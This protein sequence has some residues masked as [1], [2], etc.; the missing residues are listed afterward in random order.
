MFD[1]RSE[2]GRQWRCGEWKMLLLTSML[3]GIGDAAPYLS[4][5]STFARRNVKGADLA[6]PTAAGANRVHVVALWSFDCVS[7]Q[8]ST[9]E[10]HNLP[11]PFSSGSDHK[12]DRNKIPGQRREAA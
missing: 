11:L 12:L 4:F 8:V 6:M 3:L 2:G 7:N 9:Q 10:R 1:G 5:G